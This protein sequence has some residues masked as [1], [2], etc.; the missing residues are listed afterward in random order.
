MEG[1]ERKIGEGPEKREC[2]CDSWAE[3]ER[4]G[5]KERGGVRERSVKADNWN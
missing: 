1:I 2:A 3:E 5:V 4:E